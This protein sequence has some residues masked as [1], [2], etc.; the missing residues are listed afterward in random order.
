MYPREP[1][2]VMSV[3]QPG[4][5]HQGEHTVK[6]P[7]LRRIIAGL[8]VVIGL[9]AA[10]AAPAH[11]VEVDRDR[12]KFTEQGI[13][14]GLNWDTFGA[15]LNGGHLYWDLMNGYV[16][17]DL[18]GYLY[19]KNF[20]GDC[21]RMQMEYHDADHDV[22]YTDSSP[23]YC[24]GTNSLYQQWI[25]IDFYASPYVTHVIVRMQAEIGPNSYD[26]VASESWYLG[27][28]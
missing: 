9:V 11:A 1:G 4:R 16:I 3:R 21:G 27:T 23:T 26:T 2:W 8:A 19:F 10:T 12:P 13:D 22:L 6:S 14:F 24:A 5:S 20:G 7:Y 15:P 25:D 18:E 17:A 28:D